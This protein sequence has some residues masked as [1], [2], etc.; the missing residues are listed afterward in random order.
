MRNVCT[1]YL[2]PKLGAFGTWWQGA[3]L[4]VYKRL[5]WVW[6][7]TN[8]VKAPVSSGLTSY[9]LARLMGQ[10][11]PERAALSSLTAVPFSFMKANAMANALGPDVSAMDLLMAPGGQPITQTVPRFGMKVV[12]LQ[13]FWFMPKVQYNGDKTKTL[14]EG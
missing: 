6:R 1:P 13:M 9:G 11:N 3:G 4:G 14:S 12:M 10:K 8:D 7:N 2:A 5:W